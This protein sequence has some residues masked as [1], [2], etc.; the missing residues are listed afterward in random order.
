MVEQSIRDAGGK[1][2]EILT[3]ASAVLDEAS[4]EKLAESWDFQ[5]YQQGA[6]DRAANDKRN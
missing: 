1:F 3:R 6:R 2:T 4:R 5:C